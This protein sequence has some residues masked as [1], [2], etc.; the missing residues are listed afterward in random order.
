MQSILLDADTM[1]CA[2]S[3]ARNRGF[4][5][6]GAAYKGASTFAACHRSDDGGSVGVPS[7]LVPETN[8]PVRQM[9][10]VALKRFQKL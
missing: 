8:F 9:N 1:F 4:A 5:P 3:R 6:S 2:K 10:E 7:E